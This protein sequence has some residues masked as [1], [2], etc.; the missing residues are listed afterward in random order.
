MKSSTQRLAL[1][2]TVCCSWLLVA[3]SDEDQGEQR[4]EGLSTLSAAANPGTLQP[5]KTRRWYSS[6]N[7]IEVKI[8]DDSL[9]WT[10]HTS[11]VSVDLAFELSE[12]SDLI[13]S[14]PAKAVS[15]Q[16][17]FVLESD[18]GFADGIGE[19]LDSPY[20]VEPEKLVGRAIEV[21]LLPVT[22]DAYVDGEIARISA[23]NAA[24]EELSQNKPSSLEDYRAVNEEDLRSVLASR[25]FDDLTDE[26]LADAFIP[27]HH[28][29]EDAFE[30]KAV[31][32]RDLPKIRDALRQWA[33]VRY[34]RMDVVSD[35]S[36][37]GTVVAADSK[38][39]IREAFHFYSGYDFEEAGFS[40]S[41]DFGPCGSNSSGFD[42]AGL[43]YAYRPWDSDSRGPCF[44]KPH[45]L[46][47]A[48]AIEGA[49]S[50]LDLEQ[51]A[52]IYFAFDGEMERGNFWMDVQ[53]VDVDFFRHQRGNRP[54]DSRFERLA[55]TISL[56]P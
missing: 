2:F 41:T 35:R 34:F 8:G 50:R 42:A 25:I 27:G 47:D 1:I 31:R 9:A 12:K 23:A 49:R 17:Q 45:T 53:R 39:M 6:S 5:P 15:P 14:D 24:R 29:I 43:S 11:G 7:G 55:G 22:D 20:R 52:M 40:V 16:G 10:N 51:H 48:Q 19:T 32:D 36:M 54:G 13:V 26:Q 37:I 21:T 46:D 18:T 3:C 33:A 38:P 30:K 28:E 44:L 4:R 56:T